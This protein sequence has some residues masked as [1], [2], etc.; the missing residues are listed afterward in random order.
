MDRDKAWTVE[1]VAERLGVTPRTLHYYEE[2]GLIPE[3]PR[4]PGGH[5]VYDEDTIERI[6]HILRLKEALGY[7]LQEIRSILDT[8]DRLKTYRTRIAEGQEPEHNVEMLADAV[9]LLEDV[10]RH[11]DEKMTRLAA[12]REQYS[13]RLARIRARLQREEAAHRAVDVSNGESE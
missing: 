8:E 11:I 12:M 7:S 2:K 6:E 4:T 10:V 9:R 3:V 1:A 13:D 5:R